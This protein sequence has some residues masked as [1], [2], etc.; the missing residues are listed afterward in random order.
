MVR[1]RW[2]ALASSC[3]VL[4]ATIGVAV[5]PAPT[6]AFVP[7][8]FSGKF[9]LVPLFDKG[10]RPVIRSGHQYYAERNPITLHTA[11]GEAVT[12]FAGERTD[13]ASIP[14]AIWPVLP[15]DG[16]WSEAA[17]FHDKCY[18]TKGTFVAPPSAPAAGK[19]GR[20]RLA[21]YDRAGC[22]GIL[23]EGMIS[24]GV[25]RWKRVVIY[26]AVRLGGGNGWGR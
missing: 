21:P 11:D 17:A 25:V 10:H 18:K 8:S 3:A 2:T 6:V 14:A 4:A 24:L 23:R 7:A 1:F 9:E 20:T 5:S 19:I 12:V 15:P 13:L 16:T 22:D 26:D